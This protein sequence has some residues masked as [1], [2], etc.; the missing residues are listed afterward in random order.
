MSII[1]CVRLSDG[2]LLQLQPYSGRG[3]FCP[4]DRI[5][6]Q[7]DDVVFVTVTPAQTSEPVGHGNSRPIGELPLL[8]V[9][10]ATGQINLTPEPWQL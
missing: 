9:M 1:P 10:R 6:A 2:C 5:E 3:R 7:G 8:E 4:S